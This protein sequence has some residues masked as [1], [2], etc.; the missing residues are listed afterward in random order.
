MPQTDETLQGPAATT[1]PWPAEVDPWKIASN[2][3]LDREAKLERLRQLELDVRLVE[4]SLEE[5][6]TGNTHLPPLAEVLKAI[7]RV[8]NHREGASDTGPAKI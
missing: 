2:P 7:D 6:M 5:G 1:R 8:S 4:N 3:K